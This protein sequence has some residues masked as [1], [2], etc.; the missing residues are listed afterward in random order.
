[1]V[2]GG[3]SIPSDL[4]FPPDTKSSSSRSDI[5]GENTYFI[6]NCTYQW[7]EVSIILPSK[8]SKRNHEHNSW[9]CEG[10]RVVRE[11]FGEKYFHMH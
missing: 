10:M 5:D 7:P 6:D 2:L 11:C 3:S 1:M 8:F 4:Q 9:Y